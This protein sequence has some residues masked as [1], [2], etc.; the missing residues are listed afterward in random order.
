MEISTEKL[1][2]NIENQEENL[3]NLIYNIILI[4]I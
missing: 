2:R 3:K 4:R 1:G